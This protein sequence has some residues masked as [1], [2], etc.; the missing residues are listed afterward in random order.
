MGRHRYEARRR[1][2]R[3]GMPASYHMKVLEAVRREH[4]EARQR[5]ARRRER[6]ARDEAR[7]AE[8]E[9]ELRENGLDRGEPASFDE[10][11]WKAM[12]GAAW[13]A[14]GSML[15]ENPHSRRLMKKRC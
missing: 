2:A 6:D 8:L 10:F 14:A 7:K 15:V 13:M 12:H 5:G 4:L 11:S 1:E 3:R 9:R